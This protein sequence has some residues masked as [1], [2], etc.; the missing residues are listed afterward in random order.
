[1]FTK[2]NL[3]K[4]KSFDWYLNLLFLLCYVFGGVLFTQDFSFNIM[5]SLSEVFL[6]FCFLGFLF[7]IYF[8]YKLQNKFNYK[9]FTLWI[10]VTF[11]ITLSLE[12]IGSSTGLIFGNYKYGDTLKLQI[13]NTPLIIGFNWIII[14]LSTTTIAS[15]IIEKFKFLTET[16]SYT[17]YFFVASLA[18]LLATFF[19][20]ILEPVAVYLNF[21]VWTSSDPYQIPLQN[22]IAWFAIT[23][24]FSYFYLLLNLKIN[25]R[26]IQNIFWM[27]LIFFIFLRIFLF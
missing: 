14:I 27:Q 11:F 12:I 16:K 8:S 17:K 26:F 19:D 21:W 9:V 13:F 5:K 15:R 18:G 22:Y 20:F 24:V 2:L 3:V 10:F 7:A 25:S 23:F 6:Y 4:T 1:M